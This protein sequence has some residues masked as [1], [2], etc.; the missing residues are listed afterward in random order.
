MMMFTDGEYDGIFS[1]S[2]IQQLANVIVFAI[3]PPEQFLTGAI[4]CSQTPTH[5]IRDV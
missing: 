2:S 5:W 4:A 3:V 1:C